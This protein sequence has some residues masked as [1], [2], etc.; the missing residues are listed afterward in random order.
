MRLISDDTWAALT[1]WCEAR[2]EAQQGRVGVAEVIRNR[3]QQHFMS[4][5]TVPG[6]VLAPFQFSAFNTRDPNR[7]AA[8]KLD[9]ENTVLRQCFEAWFEAMGGSQVTNGALYYLNPMAVAS[10]PTWVDECHEVAAIGRHR[11]FKPK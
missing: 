1:I 8:A 5:G 9:T 11:F 10:M 3:T 7:I 6:T 4:D 2:G